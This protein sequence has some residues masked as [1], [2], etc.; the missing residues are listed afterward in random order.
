VNKSPEI[1][2]YIQNNR[3]NIIVKPSSPEN[4]I[5]EFDESRQALRV[6]IAAPPEKDRANR[7]II[8]F[9]SKILGKKVELAAGASSKRKVLRIAE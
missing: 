7:E 5:L 9:F 3:L 1:S 4:R 8:R 2:K 6:E